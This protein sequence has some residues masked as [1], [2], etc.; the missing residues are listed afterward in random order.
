MQLKI[1]N[2]QSQAAAALLQPIQPFSAMWAHS[3][4]N[5]NI[6]SNTTSLNQYASLASEL[7]NRNEQDDEMDRIERSVEYCER[8]NQHEVS[9]PISTTKLPL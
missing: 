9:C 4:H 1:Q 2:N 7:N 8:R 3:N 6:I 5:R